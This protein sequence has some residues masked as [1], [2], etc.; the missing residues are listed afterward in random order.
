MRALNQ[1]EILAISGATLAENDDR[2]TPKLNFSLVIDSAIDGA[3]AGF[4]LSL[5]FAQNLK[6]IAL[7]GAARW[8]ATWLA[9][10]TR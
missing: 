4:V 2:L 5:F 1:S 3:M 8:T 7:T 9:G 6:Q 10:G